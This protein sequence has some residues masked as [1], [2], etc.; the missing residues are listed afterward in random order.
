MSFALRLAAGG[1]ALAAVAVVLAQTERPP[2]DSV[3]RGYR[4]TGMDEV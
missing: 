2:M 4:G 1:F 3:Q